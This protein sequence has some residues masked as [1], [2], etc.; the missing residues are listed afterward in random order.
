MTN[1]TPLIIP[2]Y[3]Q[4]TY[5]KNIINWWNW[6]NPGHPVFI[7]DN[8]S[9]FNSPLGSYYGTLDANYT[10]LDSY[11]NY[12]ILPNEGVYCFY[13]KENDCASNLKKFIDTCIIGKYDYY[14]ISD[15]DIMIHPNT[16]PNFLEV[17]KDL[18]DEKGYHHVGFNLITNDLPN[19]LENKANIVQNESELLSNKKEEYMGF[20]GYKAPIDTTFAM[21]TTKNSGWHSPM[22]GESWSN[23]LRIFNAFHLGWY[24]NPD[25]V[26]PEMDNY[27]KTS[28]QHIPG[29]P[30]AG[31]NNNRPNK[32]IK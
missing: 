24:I 6:Y 32:Y 5:L 17:F 4:L 31:R 18:I 25:F 20:P 15:P 11:I 26:N 13:N 27:F 12:G 30:S 19:W 3:N 22:D 2:N 29:Q 28:T 21:Y 23:S 9:D 16:P 7:I 14:C 1:K 8:G 10:R